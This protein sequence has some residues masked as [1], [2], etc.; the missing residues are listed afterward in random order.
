MKGPGLRLRRHRRRRRREHPHPG[1]HCQR[2]T[3]NPPHGATI[4]PLTGSPTIATPRGSRANTF[5][6]VCN[7]PGRDFSPS[8]SVPIP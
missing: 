8:R 6:G 4:R 1:Q 3:R 5:A 7:A 2:A